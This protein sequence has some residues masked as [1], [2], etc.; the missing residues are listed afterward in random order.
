M[1]VRE[2]VEDI[3]ARFRGETRTAPRGVRGRVYESKIGK[4]RG[5]AHAVGTKPKL[6]VRA[7]VKRANNDNWEDLGV[8]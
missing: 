7:R 5:G 8:L 4:G 1:S 3:K 6:T 2:I